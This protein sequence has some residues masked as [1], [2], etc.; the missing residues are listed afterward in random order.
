MVGLV[1]QLNQYTTKDRKTWHVARQYSNEEVWVLGLLK[2]LSVENLK[3]AP[4]QERVKI[5]FTNTVTH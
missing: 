1:P 5:E 2:H 4:L 3:R